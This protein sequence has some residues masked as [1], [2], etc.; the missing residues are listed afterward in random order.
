M[1]STK[2]ELSNCLTLKNAEFPSLSITLY[3][4]SLQTFHTLCTYLFPHNY[5]ALLSFCLRSIE[6]SKDCFQYGQ[7]ICRSL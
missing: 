6:N 2:C 4:T 3:A 5:D 7:V 1:L